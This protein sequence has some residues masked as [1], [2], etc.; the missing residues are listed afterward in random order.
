[1]KPYRE[2]LLEH[3]AKLTEFAKDHNDKLVA[4]LPANDVE[5]RPFSNN[6]K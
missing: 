5:P 4:E 3:R 1:M 6:R 2:A